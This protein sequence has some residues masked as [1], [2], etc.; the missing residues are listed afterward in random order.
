M[1]VRVVEGGFVVQEEDTELLDKDALKVVTEAQPTPEQMEEE[2]EKNYQ[3]IRLDIVN[4]LFKEQ[5]NPT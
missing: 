1:V 2:V 3:K 5:N 4:L